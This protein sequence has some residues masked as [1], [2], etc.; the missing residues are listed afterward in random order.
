MPITTRLLAACAAAMVA[1]AMPALT[2]AH[3]DLVASEPAAD[4]QLDVPPTEVVLAF[5]GELDPAASSLVIADADGAEVGSGGVDLGVAERNVLR[6]EVEIDGDGEY[7]VTWTATA[8]D[9]HRE[10]GTFTFRV[11]ATGTAAP[12]TALP[13]PSPAL[14][15]GIALVAV[16][17]LLPL[18]RAARR[19]VIAALVMLPLVTAA[20]VSQNRPASCDDP[21]VTVDLQLTAD[22]LS[23]TDPAV[24]RGQQV[25]LVIDSKVDGVL[26][27][28]GYDEALPAT[29][30]TAGEE[31]TLEFTATRSGQFPVELHTDEVTTGVSVG[32]FTVHE[33]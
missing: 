27:V 7:E 29:S 8:L 11:G 20:C 30:V 31:L 16:A 22:S 33:P 3:A 28:H 19:H 21:S 32:V 13:R 9:G 2:M 17:L 5:D 15:A 25:T 18:G 14:P 23:P 10:E 1:A 12:D 24:C 6:A 26:H 4:T